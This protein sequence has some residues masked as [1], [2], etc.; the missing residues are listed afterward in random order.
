MEQGEDLVGRCFIH[1]DDDLTVYTISKCI[2]GVCTVTWRGIESTTYR[3]VEA[4][5]CIER[6]VWIEVNVNW[7]K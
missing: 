2:E 7:L 1:Q 5:S 6:G 3:D 4:L